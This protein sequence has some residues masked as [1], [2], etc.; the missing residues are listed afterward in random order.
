[1]VGLT[2]DDSPLLLRHA[3]TGNLRTRSQLSIASHGR[4]SYLGLK[5]HF[6]RGNRGPRGSLEVPKKKR[7]KRS[8]RGEWIRTT[9][10][11]VPNQEPTDFHDLATLPIIAK[12]CAKS[13]I[14]K[15]FQAV[16]RVGLAT[17]MR[18]VGA[19]NGHSFVPRCA[20]PKPREYWRFRPT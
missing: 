3:G 15:D 16:P 2:P 8:G 19:K 14:L 12:H 10:L 20:E 7:V 5:F 6:T 13:L 1:M 17:A 9:G 18:G 11:L 4:R